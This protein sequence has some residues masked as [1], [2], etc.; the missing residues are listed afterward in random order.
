VS[1]VSL[2]ARGG[3]AALWKPGGREAR[4]P[5]GRKEKKGWG[6]AFEL[7]QESAATIH[8]QGNGS[9]EGEAPVTHV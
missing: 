3:R 5:K 4:M 9:L 2:Y 8:L 6:M 7:S 1:L